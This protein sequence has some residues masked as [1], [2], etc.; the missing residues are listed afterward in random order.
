M[1][2]RKLARLKRAEEQKILKEH[3]G[4]YGRIVAENYPKEAE[5]YYREEKPVSKRRPFALIG[6]AAAAALVFAVSFGVIRFIGAAAPNGRLAERAA[7]S[8]SGVTEAVNDAQSLSPIPGGITASNIV[9][10]ENFL[11]GSRLA[12]VGLNYKVTEK[13]NEGQTEFYRIQ[14]DTCSEYHVFDII[15]NV[16]ND[17][18]FESELLPWEKATLRTD[19]SGPFE[20]TY[21]AV[22]K[23]RGDYYV[24]NTKAKVDTGRETY[25]ITYNYVSEN[26]ECELIELIY[27]YIKPAE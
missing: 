10:V 3:E 17:F 13:K 11:S 5:P 26:P 25:Y 6:V 19:D 22:I 20:I 21:A 18:D 16:K 23:Q 9:S 15:V 4:L 8:Y 2:L 1:S 12:L 14:V 27:Y 7:N 24:F